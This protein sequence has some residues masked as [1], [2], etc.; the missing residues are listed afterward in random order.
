MT[1]ADICIQFDNKRDYVRE[2]EYIP[3]QS[4]IAYFIH[5]IESRSTGKIFTLFL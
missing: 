1:K 4:S 5:P 2:Y 3:H